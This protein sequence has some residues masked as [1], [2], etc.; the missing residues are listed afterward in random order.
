M[1]KL[2]LATVAA[3]GASMGVATVAD[4][5]TTAP[6]PGTV[7]VRLNGRVRFYAAYVNDG[8]VDR[9][10][11]LGSPRPAARSSRT[12]GSSNTAA[13]IPASTASPRTA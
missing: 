10:T 13:S 7:T 2:L 6:A 5:Q 9:P 11:V 12:I 3:L 4:A 8:D 1:R